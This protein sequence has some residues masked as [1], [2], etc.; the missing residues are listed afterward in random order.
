MNGGTIEVPHPLLSLD[1]EVVV[2]M[3]QKARDVPQSTAMDYVA[4]KFV[5]FVTVI[6]FQSAS[7]IYSPHT[8]LAGENWTIEWAIRLTVALN[9]AKAL[10]HCSSEGR[11]LYHD[12]NAY[13]VLFDEI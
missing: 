9:I 7:G 6:S 1:H 11:P 4:D 13:M 8:S 3:S 12:L 2:I 5:I 10:D